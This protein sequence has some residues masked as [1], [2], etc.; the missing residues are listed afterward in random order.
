MN[1]EE[2]KTIKQ[3]AIARYEQRGVRPELASRLW[4]NYVDQHEKRGQL[5]LEDV[6]ETERLQRAIARR[7]SKKA[8]KAVLAGALVGG[9]LGTAGGGLGGRAGA[10]TG[11]LLGAVY[12]GIG[13]GL[14]S[15]FRKG[16][17]SKQI[18]PKTKQPLTERQ[19]NLL[20]ENSSKINAI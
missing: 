4:D 8:L 13:G 16:D 7:R 17:L 18:D 9:G 15:S 10:I 6:K 12:G 3:A 1:T 2:I 19:I 14:V 5:S 11:G 20:L